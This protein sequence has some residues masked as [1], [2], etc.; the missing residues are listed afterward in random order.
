[1]CVYVCVCV[2]VGVCV[3]VCV[4]E[5]L[6]VCVRDYNS[7]SLSIPTIYCFTSASSRNACVRMCVCVRVCV[8]AYVHVCVYVC[9]RANQSLLVYLHALL[10]DIGRFGFARC[11]CMYLCACV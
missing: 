10:L 11:V 3:C 5:R 4:L 2:C 7:S 9:V 8:C 1:V 6:C